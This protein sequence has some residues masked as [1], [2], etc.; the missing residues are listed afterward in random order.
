MSEE[1]PQDTS[2][3]NENAIGWGSRWLDMVE[4]SPSFDEAA[5]R[6]GS[7]YASFD[8]Q[9]DVE[10]E[11]G[12]ASATASSG[13]RMSYEP[14][15]TVPTLSEAEVDT[16]VASI[17][18]ETQ[19]IA[20]VLD[21][22]LPSDLDVVLAIDPADIVPTCTC[23]SVDRPCKHA[24]AVAQLIGDAIADEPFDLLHLRGVSRVDLIERLTAT[25]REANP[26]NAD[27]DTPPA[28]PPANPE[29]SEPELTW[30]TA[31]GALPADLAPPDVAGTLPAFPTP[32]PPGASFDEAGLR[33]LANDGALRAHAVLVGGSRAWVELDTTTDLARRAADVEASDQWKPLVERAQVTSQELR[34]R[35]QAWRIG[36]A[37]AVEAHI[38]PAEILTDPDD[39]DRQRRRTH[40][41]QWVA[42]EKQKGRWLAVALVDG[43]EAL[44]QGPNDPGAD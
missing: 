13:P 17:A 42:F 23:T 9:L 28:P 33:M 22:E 3:P 32:P 31:S 40:D 44:E 4:A 39:R 10:I 37:T 6:R 29:P 16:I 36:G 19:R 25:R 43:P 30:S 34:A 7:D 24:A 2:M 21:G 12:R 15:V 8:W 26:D 14:A 41:D 1:T 20:A 5:L 18:S 38:A 35:A 11:V 27:P